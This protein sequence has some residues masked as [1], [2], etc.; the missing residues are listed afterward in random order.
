MTFVFLRGW[1]MRR[2]RDMGDPM[3]RSRRDEGGKKKRSRR[4]KRV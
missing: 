3:E 2:E 4:N 1:N